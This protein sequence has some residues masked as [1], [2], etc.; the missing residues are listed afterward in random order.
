M[1]APK[2]EE[3]LR[4]NEERK[5]TMHPVERIARFHLEFEGI[6]PFID[7]NGRTGRLIMNLELIRSG[8]LPINVK[9]AD[10]KRY[11]EAF[12]A[13]YRDGQADAMILL[14]GEYVRDR[15]EEVLAILA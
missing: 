3:L 2:M 15:L 7:G 1:I 5:K 10:R 8:Y 13:Y 14:I 4:Q 11:Y 9:F 6:H 12:D